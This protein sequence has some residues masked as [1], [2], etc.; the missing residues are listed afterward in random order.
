[1]LMHIAY[2]TELT[3]PKFVTAYGYYI[4]QCC[5]TSHTA[6]NSPFLSQPCPVPA[7]VAAALPAQ[8]GPVKKTQTEQQPGGKESVQTNH[9]TSLRLDPMFNI[10]AVVAEYNI[11]ASMNPRMSEQIAI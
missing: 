3:I 5:C 11:D 7:P 6:L 8:S 4:Y 1:M 10:D 9:F 2:G